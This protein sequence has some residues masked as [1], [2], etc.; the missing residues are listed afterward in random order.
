MHI[1]DLYTFYRSHGIRAAAKKAG[2]R[3]SKLQSMFEDAGYDVR[4]NV[5]VSRDDVEKWYSLYQGGM[6]LPE[7]EV[8]VGFNRRR[9]VR[10]F[11]CYGFSLRTKE[12]TQQLKSEKIK[13]TNIANHGVENVMQVPSVVAALKESVKNRTEDQRRCTDEKRKSTSREAHG[14]DYYVTTDEFKRKSEATYIAKHGVKTPS[15]VPAIVEKRTKT[16]MANR[17]TRLTASLAE[18]GYTLLEQYAGNR[19]TVD[20]KHVSWRPYKVRHECGTCFEDDVYMFPRCPE[21]YPLN[22]S[23]AEVELEQWLIGLGEQVEHG[24]RTLIVN[25][26]SGRPYEIDLLL[27]ERKIGV[28]YNG[29]FYHAGRKD[30]GLKTDLCLSAGYKLLHVWD[31]NN[32]DAVKARLSAALGYTESIYARNCKVEQIGLDVA[33]AFTSKYHMQGST[34]A[35]Y[36]FGL[37]HAGDL[38]SVITLRS[39]GQCDHEIARF[40]SKHYIRVLGGFQKLLS[41]IRKR[42]L[43]T[44]LTYVDRDWC[45]AWEDSVYAKSGFRFQYDTGPIL[46]YVNLRTHEVSPREKYQRYKLQ[47]LFPHVY[48]AG[49]T[50]QEILVKVGIVPVWNSGNLRGVL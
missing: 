28:E 19:I 37:F 42:E 32:V 41:A 16:R 21:C 30:H 29:A 36:A 6:S 15:H 5:E 3:A 11:S 12:Q 1:E 46:R 43:G 22:R 4:R 20:G 9:I 40:C 8:E 48:S 44:L 45:P 35:S 27:P 23:I 26:A 47:E 10:E 7:V 17:A 39:S 13:A 49:L 14:V 34:L 38:V 31:F 18:R 25:P 2:F 24:N 33:A 50:A